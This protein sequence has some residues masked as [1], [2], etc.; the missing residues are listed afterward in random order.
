VDKTRG[1]GPRPATVASGS[2]KMD[3]SVV[4]ADMAA[5]RRA[6]NMYG[7]PVSQQLAD[8]WATVQGAHAIVGF[9]MGFLKKAM[10]GEFPTPHSWVAYLADQ[11]LVYRTIEGRI[12]ENKAL[13]P[14]S[15]NFM[16]VLAR[17][18]RFEESMPTYGVPIP[19]PTSASKAYAEHLQGIDPALV[20]IHVFVNHLALLFGGQRT[21]EKLEKVRAETWELDSKT[22]GSFYRF[23]EDA[24]ILRGRYIDAFDGWLTITAIPKFGVETLRKEM[25]TAFR[26]AG[27][28]LAEH[29]DDADKAIAATL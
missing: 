29:G 20:E 9:K 13:L 10:Q 7:H 8:L 6:P 4:H 1:E 28:M 15:S 22:G 16:D 17:T 12:G 25:A 26:F 19:Q 5:K 11:H 14:V 21:V 18:S 23:D 2:G 24:K 3:P 27:L